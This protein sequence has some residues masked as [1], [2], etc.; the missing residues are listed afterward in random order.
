MAAY[1]LVRRSFPPNVPDRQFYHPT[2]CRVL[3]SQD[4]MFDESVPFY[5]LFPYRFGPLPPPLLFLA[6][7]LPPV[8][9]LPPKGPTPLGMSQVDPLHGTV[10]VEVAL[11]SGGARGG[12]SGGAATGGAKPARAEPGG[13]EPA[14]AERAGAKS[15]G[16]GSGVAEPGGAEPVGAELACAEHGGAQPDVAELGSAEY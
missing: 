11:D 4:V 9:P 14:S 5:R 15:E 2:S 12:A 3:P 13:A 1:P 16:A 10:L 6:P 8:D 7:G